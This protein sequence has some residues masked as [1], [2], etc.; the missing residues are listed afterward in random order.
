MATAPKKIDLSRM[1]GKV[2]GTSQ[3]SMN[4]IG[5]KGKLIR[6]GELP[7]IQADIFI[8]IQSRVRI[9]DPVDR[10]PCPGLRQI[11]D[12]IGTDRRNVARAIKAMEEEGKVKIKHG[13][14][15]YANSE[16]TN[17]YDFTPLFELMEKNSGETFEETV[18]SEPEPVEEVKV[19]P[20]P[21][22][23]ELNDEAN[24]SEIIART[25]RQLLQY[26]KVKNETRNDTLQCD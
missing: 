25:Q 6:L 20:E 22:K 21:I 7:S 24:L 12:D 16:S 14:S 3:F 26:H 17:H 19:A 10:L 4:P 18:A 23:A 11:A 15:G 1:W 2:L 13:K 5:L 9:D 8:A